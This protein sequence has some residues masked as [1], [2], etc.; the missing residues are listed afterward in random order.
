MADKKYKQ[1]NSFYQYITGIFVINA[2]AEKKHT[3]S[4][5]GDD[6][7]DDMTTTHGRIYNFLRHN[8]IS[9]RMWLKNF[10]IQHQCYLLLSVS[11]ICTTAEFC[12]SLPTNNK[13]NSNSWKKYF[14]IDQKQLT[15]KT[16][17]RET[18][19]I[20]QTDWLQIKIH[21]KIFLKYR[22]VVFIRS[23]G[24]FSCRLKRK[25]HVH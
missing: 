16:K 5:A 6:A 9:A 4:A 3:S 17:S 19:T 25:N 11:N 14:C 15:L 7:I 12:I 13:Q 23:Y 18:V 24:A 2:T 22:Q 10:C 20:C 21:Q 1:T 8:V